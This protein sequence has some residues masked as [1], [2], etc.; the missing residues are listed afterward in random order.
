MWQVLYEVNV[1]STLVRLSL[2]VI[3]GGILGLERGL[4]GRPAGMRTYMLVCVGS[5]LVMLTNEYLHGIFSEGDP[6]RMGAQVI[7]GIGFLGAGTIIVTRDRQVRGLTSAA[8]LW[9]SA[10]MGL[11]IG[12]G[13]Y[14]GALIGAAFIFLVSMLMRKLD[15]T[16]LSKTRAI[17]LYVEIKDS[18]YATKL[19]D[20]IRESGTK[21]TYMEL[22]RP[23]YDKQN[24][25]AMLLSLLLPTRQVHHEVLA[26]FNEID[27]IEYAEEI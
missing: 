21:I 6:S 23:K 22:V 26:A 5:A 20:N 4:K 16:L 12:T 13:F 17:D 8:G 3:L 11:A 15:R 14:S 25:A 10:C 24:Q 2:A 19:L 9:A 7:S 18:A 27:F 1:V